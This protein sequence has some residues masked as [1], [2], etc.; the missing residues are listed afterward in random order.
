MSCIGVQNYTLS[1]W[2]V[3]ICA[4][5]L[6]SRVTQKSYIHYYSVSNIKNLYYIW[7][8]ISAEALHLQNT[9]RLTAAAQHLCGLD[10][11]PAKHEAV[12]CRRRRLNNHFPACRFWISASI[13]LQDIRQSESIISSKLLVQSGALQP[14]GSIWPWPHSFKGKYTRLLPDQCV[15]CRELRSESHFL[16]YQFQHQV[17]QSCHSLQEFNM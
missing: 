17:H 5:D 16:V 14:D 12:D 4:M 13:L 2:N 8:A 11:F 6:P 10:L 7:H 3:L 15:G 1:A 9:N